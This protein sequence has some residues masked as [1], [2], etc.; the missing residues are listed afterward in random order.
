MG[1]VRVRGAE[2][3]FEE[4]GTGPAFMWGHGLTS[5][6]RQENEARIFDW[7]GVTDR[8]RVIRYDA[9]GHGESE[10]SADPD[11]YSY[12][13]LGSDLLDLASTLGVDRFIAGGASMGA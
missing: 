5:S 12:A 6:R 9:R 4:A 2:L 8:F 7:S 3:A 11:D 13:L 10:A 1:T